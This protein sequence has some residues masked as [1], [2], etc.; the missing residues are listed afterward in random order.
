MDIREMNFKEFDK[1]DKR[2][3][4]IRYIILK[5]YKNDKIDFIRNPETLCVEIVINNISKITILKDSSLKEIKRGIDKKIS[6]QC[7]GIAEDCIICSKT[8]QQNVSCSKCSNNYCGECYINLFKKGKG[9]ITCPHCRYSI[10]NTM[11][12]FDIQMGVIEIKHKL[13]KNII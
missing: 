5:D 13:G 2:C 12:D 7:N 6:S 4:V 8:I 10:G 9:V 11:T 1:Y 3:D